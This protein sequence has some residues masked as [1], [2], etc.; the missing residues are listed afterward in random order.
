MKLYVITD[1]KQYWGMDVG[2]DIR[3]L[4]LDDER[5]PED[6]FKPKVIEHM[7]IDWARNYEEFKKYA[8]N[9]GYTNYDM[10][11]LDHD[12]GEEKTGFDCV[13]L[14]Y[15]EFMKCHKLNGDIFIHTYN[16]GGRTRMLAVIHEMMKIN[17]YGNK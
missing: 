3:V 12:L 6:Y 10:I 7:N 16:P 2:K 9:C 13:K 4:W 14:L 15:D 11:C 17:Q 5:N 8:G 1:G